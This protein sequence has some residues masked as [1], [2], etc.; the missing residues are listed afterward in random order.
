MAS[1][2]Q[3]R[4]L[5]GAY[6]DDELQPHE[7]EDVAHH[8]AQCSECKAILEDYQ[9]LG[10]SLRTTADISALDGFAQ[11]VQ[12]RIEKIR[13]PIRLRLSRYFDSLSEKLV[14]GAAIGAAATIAAVL[15]VVVV[16][17]VARKVVNRDGSAAGVTASVGAPLSRLLAKSTSKTSLA[18]NS[19]AS[20]SQKL[21]ANAKRDSGDAEAVISSLEADSPS[22]AVWNEPHTDTT[23]IWVPDQH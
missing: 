19:N 15:I 21:I 20:R 22:V 11:S 13:V 5:L 9:T 6:H 16:T 23:V 12:T 1:C 8:I 14:A 10:L 17:P 4:L 2:D 7:V 3:I 18:A